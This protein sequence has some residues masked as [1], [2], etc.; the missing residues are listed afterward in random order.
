MGGSALTATG[1]LPRCAAR[2]LRKHLD[3]LHGPFVNGIWPWCV[4][5]PSTSALDTRLGAPH[6][7]VMCADN[8]CRHSGRQRL[9]CAQ[10][11]PCNPEAT[12]L[13]WCAGLRFC[14][15]GPIM[16]KLQLGGQ[17]RLKTSDVSCFWLPLPEL[18]WLSNSDGC[19]PGPSEF[20]DAGQVSGPATDVGMVRGIL[21]RQVGHFRLPSFFLEQRT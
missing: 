9:E 1:P 3:A 19:C 13:P 7:A 2:I 15:S 18:L 17:S 20:E 11:F 6:G 16:R 8:W 12:A 10:A 5:L 14:C 21:R 4:R